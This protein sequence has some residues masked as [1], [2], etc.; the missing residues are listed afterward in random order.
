VESV[1]D[2][3]Y[4]MS[5]LMTLV[6]VGVMVDECCHVSPLVTSAKVDPRSGIS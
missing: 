1:V 4:H 2:K 5:M 3:S 6:G